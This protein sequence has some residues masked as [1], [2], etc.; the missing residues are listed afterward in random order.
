MDAMLRRSVYNIAHGKFELG[1]ARLK[2]LQ[3]Q[4]HPLMSTRLKGLL[5]LSISRFTGLD[6]SLDGSFNSCIRILNETI[7][8]CPLQ[9]LGPVAGLSESL[10]LI[11][12]AYIATGRYEEAIH[13]VCLA[14]DFSAENLEQVTNSIDI[15]DSIDSCNVLAKRSEK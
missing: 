15:F 4:V 5:D 7:Y 1:K 6:L 14:M 11:A 9:N 12:D 13:S 3:T 8:T 10:A 2:R